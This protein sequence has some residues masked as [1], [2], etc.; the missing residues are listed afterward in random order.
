MEGLQD[1]NAGFDVVENIT[2]GVYQK[3]REECERKKLE[4]IE[5]CSPVTCKSGSN[6][7]VWVVIPDS[8]AE[9]PPIEFPTIGVREMEWGKFAD[10]AAFGKASLKGKVAMERPQPYLDLLL[11]LWPGDWVKQLQ[12]LNSAIEK[13]P[14]SK[15]KQKHSVSQIKAVSPNE[16]FVFIGI[17]IIS[18]AIGKGG[19][20]LFEKQSERLKE[21]I[22]SITARIDLS[23]YMAVRR[24]DDI[25]TFFPQAFADFERSDV[26][27]PNYDPWYM[28]SGLIDAFNKNRSKT[29]AASV[30]K[31]LDESMSA[32]RPRKDKTGGLPNISFILRKPEP[33]G[34]E[35][36]SMACSLTG[37]YFILFVLYLTMFHFSKFNT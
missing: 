31:L 26:K 25:K 33:L 8:I 36:K 30:I 7:L 3:R 27:Q 1:D 2:S 21:G 34:T 32:W 15:A 22:F 12:Q 28:I 10:L 6:E 11:T 5:S 4:L 35:F 13:N 29:V 9:E 14:Q 19:R 37:I 17:I 24:F 20:R 16:F 18:G 23:S